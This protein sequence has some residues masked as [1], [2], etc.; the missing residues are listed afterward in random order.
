[1][2][3]S[4]PREGPP[5]SGEAIQ[6]AGRT[7]ETGR[8]PLPSNGSELDPSNFFWGMGDDPFEIVTV[9]NEWWEEVYPLG[10]YLFGQ[11]MGKAPRPRTDVV[12]QRGKTRLRDL[13]NLASYN[14]LGLS[15]RP[16]VIEAACQA[17]RLF[18]TGASGSPILSG[19]NQL[20]DELT[21]KMAAFKGR[22]ACLLYPSGYSANVGIVSALMRA[23]DLVVTDH[24]SHA[25][26][27]DGIALSKAHVKY[28]RHNNAED[29]DEKLSGFSGRKLVI[30][31]GVYSMDGDLANLP[32]IV[33]VARRHNARIMI[34]EAHSGGGGAF[35]SR[36]RD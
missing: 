13:I 31:E 14:Y 30:V 32:A 11:P 23:G 26:I 27:V 22:E 3:S 6:R 34:D 33:E 21:Q 12:E 36:G 8:N 17:V 28:F 35:Q 24:L 29:L 9:F 5:P 19:T 15:Y 1:M 16:E 18:G 10:Y 2:I 7:G 20:H 4:S 25:S